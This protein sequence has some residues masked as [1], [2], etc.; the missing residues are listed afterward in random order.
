MLSRKMLSMCEMPLDHDGE[1]CEMSK[2]DLLDT[3][4]NQDYFDDVMGRPLLSTGDTCS[5]RSR[6]DGESP[7][8]KGSERM[9]SSF[10]LG[11]MTKS[12]SKDSKKTLSFKKQRPVTL[13]SNKKSFNAQIADITEFLNEQKKPYASATKQRRMTRKVSAHQVTQQLVNQFS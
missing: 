4:S 10:I 9:V 8:R 7:F 6:V 13:R 1:I 12:I 11:S 2:A 5:D 3:D